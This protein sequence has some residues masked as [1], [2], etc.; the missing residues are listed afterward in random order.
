VALD[1]LGAVPAGRL[2]GIARTGAGRLAR[3]SVTRV[4]EALG[5]VHAARGVVELVGEQ[6]GDVPPGMRAGDVVVVWPVHRTYWRDG[7]RDA[8]PVVDLGSAFGHHAAPREYRHFVYL[9]AGT[10]GLAVIAEGIA[11]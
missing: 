5:L 4:P 6:D 3:V 7:R 10:A 11:A 9:R 8:S 1:L 2:M